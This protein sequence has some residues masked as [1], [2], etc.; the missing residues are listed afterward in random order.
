MP[1]CVSFALCLAVFLQVSMLSAYG[2]D[3]PG[4][5]SPN[6]AQRWAAKGQG[7]TPE[8]ERHVMPLLGKIGCANRACHGS[9]QGQGG[10]Q[11]SLFASDPAADYKVLVKEERID[12]E[13]PDLSLALMKP[14]GEDPISAINPTHRA[15]CEIPSI[16]PVPTTNSQNYNSKD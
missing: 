10:L 14:L 11:L 9:F 8:F 2:D 15:P 7:G 12:L 1:Q 6:V 5:N 4:D 3:S 13:D 16:S